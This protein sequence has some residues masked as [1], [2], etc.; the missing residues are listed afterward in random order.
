MRQWRGRKEDILLQGVLY[1][2]NDEGEIRK[3]LIGTDFIEAVITLGD[4]IF[5]GTGLSPC[6]LILRWVERAELVKNGWMLGG[7]KILTQKR[8]QNILSDEDV[9]RLYKLYSDFAD[10]EDYARVVTRE[11]I[12]EKG[13]DLSVN[14][15]VQYHKE[16]VK[17]YAEMKADFD[18]A[19]DEV[20]K[21]TAKFRQLL[22]KGG[23][24]K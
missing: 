17:S 13:Y 20:T 18:A 16:A 6:V 24:L 22:A 11:E 15:Y 19:L 1:R 2:D 4:K 21:A 10:V 5:Y 3:Q 9:E 14:K 23:L 7:S 8:A 12:A